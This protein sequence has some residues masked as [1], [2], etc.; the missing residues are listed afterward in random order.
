MKRV[1]P[2]NRA[3]II[4]FLFISSSFSSFSQSITVGKVEVG[5][6]IGPLVFLGDLGGAQGVGQTFV[7]DIDFPLVKLNKGLFVN[8]APTEWLGFRLAINQGV[9]EGDDKQAPNKGG[10]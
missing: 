4:A 9:L 3:M 5:V 8:I 2:I 1:V 10:D 6:G 7:K